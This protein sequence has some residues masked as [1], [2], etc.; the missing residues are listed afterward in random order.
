M[1]TLNT[2]T[3]E[4]NWC[5]CLSKEN[6]LYKKKITEEHTDEKILLHSHAIKGYK[7]INII[8]PRTDIKITVKTNFDYGKESYMYALISKGGKPLLDLDREK[9]NTIKNAH[10]E[11]FSVKQGEW[12][13]LFDKI[14]QAV[15]TTDISTKDII[16]YLKSIYL[17]YSTKTIETRYNMH[18]E[19]TECKSEF[20][21]L[22]HFG[23]RLINLI[24]NLNDHHD[25]NIVKNLIK[26]CKLWLN[27]CNSILAEID[28]NDS[29]FPKIATAMHTAYKY[30]VSNHIHN[31]FLK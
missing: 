13:K 21:I 28:L 25:E 23:D 14:I 15:N 11:R 1:N 6:I 5:L 9:N 31:N 26:I 24:K 16:E 4:Y 8:I 3:M 29:H 2:N 17:Y 18:C 7:E 22:E 12:G 27:R 20:T 19:I 10:L 30:M